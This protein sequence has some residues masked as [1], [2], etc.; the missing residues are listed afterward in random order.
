MA[1][2]QVGIYLLEPPE[3]LSWHPIF[4]GNLNRSTDGVLKNPFQMIYKMMTIQEF[5]SYLQKRFAYQREEK[6]VALLSDLSLHTNDLYA[7]YIY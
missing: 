7:I 6:E 2:F 3:Y 5:V 1:E 4:I